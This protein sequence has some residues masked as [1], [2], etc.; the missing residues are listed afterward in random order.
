MNKLYVGGAFT[1]CYSSDTIS[2]PMLA[3]YNGSNFILPSNSGWTGSGVTNFLTH[4]TSLY[5][6]GDFTLPY[7][8]IRS[9][10]NMVKYNGTWG[11]TAYSLN[12]KVNS[13]IYYNGNLYA[14]GAFH[15]S[16]TGA[17]NYIAKYDS[18]NHKWL[19]V[20]TGMTDGDIRAMEVFNGYLYVAGTF[21]VIDGVVAN[22]IAKWNDTV[23]QPVG[24]GLIGNVNCLKTFNGMLYAGGEFLLAGVDTMNHITALDASGVFH[25]LG[26]NGIGNDTTADVKCMEIH[27]GTLYIGGYFSEANGAPGNAVVNYNGIAFERMGNGIT[28]SNGVVYSLKSWNGSLYIAGSFNQADSISA[29][30]ICKYD[31]PVGIKEVNNNNLVEVYPNPS[32]GIINFNIQKPQNDNCGYI[33]LFDVTGRK[34]IQQPSHNGINIMEVAGLEKGIYIYKILGT[35]PSSQGKIII[36]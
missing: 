32:N 24:L 12:D 10:T 31:A 22:Y 28:S 29:N 30:N 2:S 17:V 4:D 16:D 36:E 34:V 19:N 7:D 25:K 8:T 26:A 5:V 9:I 13:M 11:D 6:A 33:Q 3:V 20:N 21:S 35:A 15:S 1:E 18:I 14:G 27:D 23:W